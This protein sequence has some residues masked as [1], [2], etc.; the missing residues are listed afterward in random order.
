MQQ[1]SVFHVPNFTAKKGQLNMAEFGE[2]QGFFKIT[3]IFSLQDDDILYVSV[4]HKQNYKT[5]NEFRWRP[6]LTGDHYGK[7]MRG[8]LKELLSQ[9]QTAISPEVI[10]AK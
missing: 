3:Q 5:S 8:P 1:A 9:S 10:L 7:V 6:F 2:K 4:R